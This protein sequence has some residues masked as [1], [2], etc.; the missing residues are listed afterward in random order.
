MKNKL[1]FTAIA[2][3]CNEEQFKAIEPKLKGKITI[4]TNPF[5]WC[6]EKESYLTNDFNYD[7][8]VKFTLT[9][10]SRKVYE[11]WNEE[12]FLNACGIETEETFTVS[13]SFV[14]DAHSSA[15]PTWKSKIEKEFP[16]LFIKEELVLNRWY[17]NNDY[18]NLVYLTK[19][20]RKQ[21]PY[22]EF[23]TFAEGY[24]FLFN[25]KNEWGGDGLLF[26][27]TRKFTLATPQEVE[28]ALINEARKRGFKEGV[29]IKT[30]VN[31]HEYIVNNDIFSFNEKSNILYLS[32]KS[33]FNNGNFAEILPQPTELTVAE[34]EAKLGYS[35]K[36][37]K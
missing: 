17:K 3:R 8:I 25:D 34:I 4:D 30:P 13:K 7:G 24:G 18:P 12:I 21:D 33:I 10:D 32:G 9:K 5:L 37:I 29:K 31:K 14:L 11:T 35:I 1:E 27:D 19:L 16:S 20:N 2:M 6:N 26:A 28:T 36:I 23:G 22:N 15:C